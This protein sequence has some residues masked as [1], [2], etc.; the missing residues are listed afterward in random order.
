MLKVVAGQRSGAY[1]TYLYSRLGRI[2]IE[3]QA[4]RLEKYGIQKLR[5]GKPLSASRY[6]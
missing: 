5:D 2:F 3:N 1:D 4:I 6:E